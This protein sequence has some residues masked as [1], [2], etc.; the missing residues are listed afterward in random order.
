MK[1]VIIIGIIVIAIGVGSFFF[2]DEIV[3][4]ESIK[5]G[6][7]LS[8]TGPGSGFG[9]ENR[10]GM[11]M[12]VDEINSRGGINGR[13]IELIILDNET[14]QEKAK[15]DFLEIEETHAP[16]MYISS[17]STITAAVSPLAE[18]HEV[19]LMAIGATATNLTV[20]KKWI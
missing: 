8:E 3:D 9:I 5:I 15:K 14:N 20:E 11:L 19:V 18:E 16:L 13:P 1:P 4:R 17:L 10:D 7:T 12:A 2:F 6:V